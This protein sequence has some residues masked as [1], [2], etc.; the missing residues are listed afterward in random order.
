MVVVTATMVYFDEA[1]TIDVGDGIV[2]GPYGPGRC[3]AVS[4]AGD[5]CRHHRGH[6][7]CHTAYDDDSHEKATC[8]W[9]TP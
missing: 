3:E 1:V 9:Y 2:F 4:P 8:R 7:G 5:Q 6:M